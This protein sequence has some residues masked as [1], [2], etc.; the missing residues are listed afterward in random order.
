M[1]AEG[2][3]LQNRWAT[4]VDADA[5]VLRHP[6]SIPG[7][8]IRVRASDQDRLDARF[9][10]TAKDLRHF[11]HGPESSIGSIQKPFRTQLTNGEEIAKFNR[12]IASI[13]LLPVPP[14]AWRTTR[15]ASCREK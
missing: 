6:G 7:A 3:A 2:N 9:L 4:H 5:E 1:N 13:L 15:G 10:L 12:S 11:A 14:P 8:S